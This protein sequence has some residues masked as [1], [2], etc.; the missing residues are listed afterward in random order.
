MENEKFELS[1]TKLTLFILLIV[2]I[3][4]ASVSFYQFRNQYN[5]TL[6]KNNMQIEYLENKYDN[7][8]AISVVDVPEA[9]NVLTGGPFKFGE[10]ILLS[11]GVIVNVEN[12][13]YI[14][15]ISNGRVMIDFLGHEYVD[16][17]KY[18]ALYVKVYNNTN[19]DYILKNE[20]FE[21]GYIKEESEHFTKSNFY[22]NDV[23]AKLKGIFSLNTILPYTIREGYVFIPIED[24][25]LNNFY[26]KLNIDGIPLVFR[27]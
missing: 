22:N 13:G 20:D 7:S 21:V 26:F 6:T 18:I 23:T 9:R 11:S 19:I 14:D 16:Y 8:K 27:K 12:K 24:T 3:V 2:M 25:K 1:K 4:V 5:L 10:N 15:D 17:T